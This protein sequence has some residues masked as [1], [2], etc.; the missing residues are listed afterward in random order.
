M[1]GTLFEIVVPVFL[2]VGA[3][4]GAVR[5][6]YLPDAIV[7]PLV[8][9][10]VRVTVP[11]LLFLAMYRLDLGQAMHPGALGAFF[12]AGTVAFFGAMALSRLVW[13]RRP[14]EAVVVG[15]SAFF[16]NAVM[17]GIPIA[18][19]AFGPATLAAVFG[20]I[21]FHSVYNYFLGFMVMEAVRRDSESVLA[22]ARKAFVTAFTNPLMVGLMAGLAANILDLPLP[23]V[24][25]DA[26]EMLARAALPVALF[27]IGGV[28]TRY[29]VRDE[30]GEALMVSAFSLV[31][32][33]GLAWVL[34]AHVFA[35]ADDY[36]RAAVVMAAMP[37]GINS[38]IFATIFN[39]AVGTAAS[40]V[41]LATV[42]SI[43]TI[44]GWLA[45]LG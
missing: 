3:G 23:G 8:G 25:E 27:S 2:I 43:G 26:L 40:S 44:T 33:P 7:D 9:I 45:F 14:G 29:R 22:G 18:E 37:T 1:L 30:I 15:F 20:I 5:S 24:A 35:L 34:T 31:V 36:V 32:H 6:R 11:A 19:R 39:R 13:H 16:P 4:Y 28:L 38:Y 17:L 42:L 10:G 21:A 41:L 12:L